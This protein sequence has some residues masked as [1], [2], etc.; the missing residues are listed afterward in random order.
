M[1]RQAKQD[2]RQSRIVR[3]CLLASAVALALAANPASAIDLSTDNVSIRLD[4]TISYAIGARASERD[5]DLVAKAFFNP[6]IIQAPLEQ[7]MAATGRFSANSD[8][9]NLNFD[10]WDPIFNQARI[11]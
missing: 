3:P 4:T 7:Q 6:L 10:Q 9:G 1:N 11:T 5:D 2:P 8:D